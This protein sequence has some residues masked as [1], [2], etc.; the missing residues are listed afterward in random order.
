MIPRTKLIQVTE[1]VI[2]SLIDDG[3]REAPRSI[4]RR[5]LRAARK[6]GQLMDKT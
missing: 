2:Q 1:S 3:V 5:R 6:T 4:S